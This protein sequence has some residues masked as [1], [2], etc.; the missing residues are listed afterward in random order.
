[1]AR[2]RM[3]AMAAAAVLVLAGGALGA[4]QDVRD[5]LDGVSKI[6]APGVPGP[7][8]V[9]GEHAFPVVAG[10]IGGGNRAPVVA[11]APWGEGRIV[12]FGHEGYFDAGSLAAGDTGRLVANAVRWA[13]GR[14]GVRAGHV[15]VAVYNLGGLLK[16]LEDERFDAQPIG[17]E[18][19]TGKLDSYDVLC[20]I[21]AH[22]GAAAEIDAIREFVR[23]G[24]GLVAADLGWGWQQLNP[25]KD[26]ISD[27][28]GN[29]LL[30]G[31]GLMWADGYL[32]RTCDVGYKADGV[33]L[34]LTHAGRAL[35]ALAA[36]A[37]GTK[38]LSKGEVTQAVWTLTQAARTLPPNDEILRPKL[39]HLRQEHTADAILTPEK[40]LTMDQPLAR[41]ALALD[42]TAIKDLPP[43]E[44]KPHPAAAEFPGLV[45]DDAPRVTRTVTIDTRIPDWHSTGLYAAPGELIR[46]TVP[47]TAA[48]KG[49]MVRIG[50]HTDSLW[51]LDSWA[52]CPEICRTFPINDPE[53][54]AANAFGG[55]IY[56]EVPRGSGLGTVDVTIGGAVEAPWFVLGKT[57]PEEWRTTIRNH[58]AQWAE[59]ETSKVIITMPSDI[60]RK[61]DDPTEV[62][63][64]WDDVMD[65]CADL[66]GRPR[67]RERPERYVPDR[68]ISIGYMH[69]GYP[70]MTHLD[71]CEVMIDKKRMMTNGHGGVWGLFHE[72]GH[73][74]QEGDW[75]FDGTGE[76]T[77]N[78]FTLYVFDTV[79]GLGITGHPAFTPE[80]RAE[81]L[82][83]YFANGAKFE[84][85]KNDPFL[86]LIMYIQL[87][88]AF[89][90]DPYKA[91]FR[92]YRE[93]GAGQHPK[94]DDEKRDQWMVRFSRQVGRNLGPFFEAWGVPTSDEARAS[95]TDLPE[96]MPEGFPPR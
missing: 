54:K 69:S 52:R 36:H 29:R 82:T 74:H 66:A 4:E 44:V 59:L 88:E 23:R 13:D 50:C 68:Q 25:T 9:F 5:L 61:L 83:K 55:L 75:T 85:W 84:G 17:G 90:W 86:A 15:R 51:H 31:T 89:G 79:C 62:L 39:R 26:L 34:D 18:G 11:A 10:D 78:L 19:W 94:S 8:C 30:A 22:I 73:N 67:E 81:K 33:Q 72:S 1:M 27:H 53:A 48:G 93:L 41:L 3:M 96:W 60:A 24:G 40:P 56:I 65:A 91:V 32:S 28:P 14:A 64:F 38:E 20:I 37:G 12:A 2:M 21:P 47:Q 42:L 35:D 16:F 87:Q 95:I 76:V 45:P 7:I 80:A 77:V 71:I 63:E 46:V 43:D 6:A 58:P 92:E 70:L 49:L 57:D